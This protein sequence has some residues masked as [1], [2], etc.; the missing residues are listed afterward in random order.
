MS[1]S[2]VEL[3]FDYSSIWNKIRVNLWASNNNQ[4][5]LGYFN[6]GNIKFYLENMEVQKACNC[7]VAYANIIS[8]FAQADNP[9]LRVFINGFDVASDNVQISVSPTNLQN[10]RLTVRITIGSTTKLNKIWL[11]WLAFSKV[12]KGFGV[13]GGQISRSGFSG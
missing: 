7:T 8:P 11:S 5:Q 1:N 9:I 4:L 13:Y 3:Q 6:V 12:N 10:T 2:A